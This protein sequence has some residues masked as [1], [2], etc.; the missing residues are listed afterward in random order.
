MCELANF[1]GLA[2]ADKGARVDRLELLLD[3]ACDFGA[4]A[5]GQRAEFGQRIF[6]ADA[7]RRSGLDPDQNRAFGALDGRNWCKT[8]KVTS[9]PGF[10]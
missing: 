1:S 2:A 5:L 8:Q 7:V 9:V 10:L 4:S 3:L 6:G